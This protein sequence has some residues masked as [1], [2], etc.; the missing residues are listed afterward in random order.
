M[1]S[2]YRLAPLP[3]YRRTRMRPVNE[4]GVAASGAWAYTQNCRPLFVAERSHETDSEALAVPPAGAVSLS[5]LPPC[6]TLPVSSA[7]VPP[8][9]VQS[10]ALSKSS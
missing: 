6:F 8:E 3:V 5:E 1:V 9:A 2:K 7:T 10:V 4:P